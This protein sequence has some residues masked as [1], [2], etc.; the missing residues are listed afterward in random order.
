[1]S[2]PKK[3]LSS[4]TCDAC[5]WDV[6][7]IGDYFYD[8]K[9]LHG[10]WGLLCQDCFIKIGTMVGQKYRSEDRNKVADLHQ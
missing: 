2:E 3:W 9:T 4:T 5:D 7:S 8:A 1:M 6:R 10:L